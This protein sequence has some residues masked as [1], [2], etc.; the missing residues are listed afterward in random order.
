MSAPDTEAPEN[1]F[2][3]ML[4]INNAEYDSDSGFAEVLDHESMYRDWPADGKKVYFACFTSKSELEENEYSSEG[5]ILL[6][7]DAVPGAYHRIG[8]LRVFHPLP[9]E[10]VF[11]SQE[12]SI[13]KEEDY[14][15]HLD[16]HTYVYKI[17]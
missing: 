3:N 17:V 4:R 14:L 11:K 13:L 7:E 5:I 16:G 10:V 6:R 12:F 15:R 2:L 8:W 9:F 1:S